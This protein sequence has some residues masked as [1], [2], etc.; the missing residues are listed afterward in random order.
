MHLALKQSNVSGATRGHAGAAP[1]ASLTVHLA[2]IFGNQLSGRS[3]LSSRRIRV[4]L[5][6]NFRRTQTVGL[7]RPTY[8][9]LELRTTTRT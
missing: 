6:G 7:S 9:K 1:E 8:C 3:R 5:G 4:S 2:R